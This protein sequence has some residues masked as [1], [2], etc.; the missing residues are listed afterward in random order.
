MVTSFSAALFLVAVWVLWLWDETALR[1]NHPGLI[2]VPKLGA[3]YTLWL[4]QEARS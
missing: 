4:Q 2:Y 3:V 1:K